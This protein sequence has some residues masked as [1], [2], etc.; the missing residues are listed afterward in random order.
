MN[1]FLKRYTP[2]LL[3]FLGDVYAVTNV[4]E[5]K[6][7]FREEAS[8]WFDN[9]VNDLDRYLAGAKYSKR[10]GDSRITLHLE[11]IFEAAGKKTYRRNLSAHMDLPNLQEKWRLIFTTYSRDADRIEIERNRLKKSKGVDKIGT[12]FDFTK[13]LGDFKTRFEPRLVI[14]D[15]L[16]VAYRLS[17]QN[18]V[19]QGLYVFDPHLMLFATGK[20]GTGVF[21]GLTQSLHLSQELRF[22]LV[23][24][25]QYADG[26]N[27]FETNNGFALELRPKASLRFRYSFIG[28]S[29]SRPVYSV[30]R[31][32][33]GFEHYWLNSKEDLEIGVSPI[34]SW[35]RRNGFNR[36]SE[37]HIQ[38]SLKF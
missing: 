20:D 10:D 38:S 14:S 12:F 23:N 26:Y 1:K 37:C 22:D 30:K 25:L 3:Y 11:A 17:F 35:P 31:W 29:A 5:Q 8:L 7:S 15:H 9:R 34:L 24:D 16:E 4:S 13:T 19:D 33:M 21:L 36:V 2:L 28:E 6:R 27:L 18:K 32:V